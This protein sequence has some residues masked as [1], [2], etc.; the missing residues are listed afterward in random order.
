MQYISTGFIDYFW[1]DGLKN[2]L[3]IWS[4]ELNDKYS[5][6]RKRGIQ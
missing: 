3:R 6:H 1:R 5:G 4:D 2:N